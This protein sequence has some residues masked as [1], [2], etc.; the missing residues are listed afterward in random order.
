MLIEVVLAT[1]FTMYSKPTKEYKKDVVEIQQILQ[2]D[3]KCSPEKLEIIKKQIEGT[4]I[5]KVLRMSC[6]DS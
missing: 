2:E 5:A 3:G 1:T 4:K 6:K